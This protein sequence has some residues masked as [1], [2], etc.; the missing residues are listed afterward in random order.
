MDPLI[1]LAMRE[2]PAG[3]EKLQ[4]LGHKAAMLAESAC[5]PLSD[6]VVQTVMC[7]KL[8]PHQV[9]RVVEYTNH[10][11]FNQKFSSLMGGP[12]RAVEFPA[13]PADPEVVMSMLQKKGGT[14]DVPLD[15]LDYSMPPMKQSSVSESEFWAPEFRTQEGL[16][17]DVLGLRS[18]V[19]SAH[20]EISND[21]EVSKYFMEQKLEALRSQ[22]KLALD[23]GA[24][25]SRLLNAWAQVDRELAAPTADRLFGSV[26]VTKVA[27]VQAPINPQHPVVAEFAGFSKEA[28]NYATKV[29]AVRELETELHKL[30]TWIRN[31]GR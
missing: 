23:Q 28:R 13:G 2:V 7:E 19:A 25:P 20:E 6:A 26:V 5:I 10:E 22:V 4:A 8:N 1:K 30:D 3:P 9:Q 11:A 29:A 21:M 17:L 27:T 14:V 18:K 31:G 24:D 15:H 16:R 12:H